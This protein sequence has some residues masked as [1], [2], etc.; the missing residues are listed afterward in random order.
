[1]TQRDKPEKQ[2]SQASMEAGRRLAACRVKAGLTQAQLSALTGWRE[3]LPR[4]AGAYGPSRI[5]MYEQ[6][7]RTIGLE[8]AQRFSEIF[9]DYH[10]AYFMAAISERESRI[11]MAA[12]ERPV[13]S[14]P[15][16]AEES[17]TLK[18]AE[19]TRTERRAA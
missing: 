2:P 9:S 11:L 17:I 3:E 19:K 16:Q 4:R 1:M 8:E 7:K 14:K 15:M 13:P 12:K 18:K 10:P 6:G 5:G